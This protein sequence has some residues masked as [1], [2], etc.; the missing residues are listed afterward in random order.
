MEKFITIFQT[1]AV[2][3]LGDNIAIVNYAPPSNMKLI[4]K[5]F[6]I[7]PFSQQKA[8]AVGRVRTNSRVS[9]LMV[10]PN[11]MFSFA[12]VVLKKRKCRN[13]FSVMTNVKYHLSVFTLCK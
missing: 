6:Y 2:V 1:T 10:E 8:Y 4:S 7:P 9:L 13:L 5:L 11:C 12:E 3:L